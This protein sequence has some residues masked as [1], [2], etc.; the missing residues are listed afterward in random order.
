MGH[1]LMADNGNTPTA[2]EY[3]ARYARLGERADNIGRR[4]TDMETEMRR[5]FSELTASLNKLSTDLQSSSKTPWPVIVSAIGVSF[6]IVAGLGAQALGPIREAQIRND[7]S[8]AQLAGS[9]V[10]RTELDSRASRSAEDRGRTEQTLARAEGELVPRKEHERVWQNYDQ[11][12]SDHQRQI[13]ELKQQSANTYNARDVLL[14][15]RERLDRV[16]RQ[17]LGG[18]AG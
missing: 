7:A 4:Q 11:R 10:P 2:G 18:S 8:I 1:A 3:D 13:D 5:G 14:D 15:L 12:L 17:R 9:T 16:E 6:A